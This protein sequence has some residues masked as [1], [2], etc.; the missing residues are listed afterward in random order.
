[1]SLQLAI[2]ALCIVAL[3]GSGVMVAAW[4]GKWPALL[5]FSDGTALLQPTAAIAGLAFA[6]ALLMHTFKL[7]VPALMAAAVPLVLGG[8]TLAAGA[9]GSSLFLDN[10]LGT[11]F[12]SDEFT[13]PGRM[14]AYTAIAFVCL[15]L[16]V[17][18]LALKP[19][20]GGVTLAAGF[21]SV[22][23]G[24][25]G[26]SSLSYLMGNLADFGWGAYNGV[27]PQA[28]VLV[29]V[30]ATALMAQC[31]LVA[32]RSEAGAPRGF[33]LPVGLAVL[34]S[35][36]MAFTSFERHEQLRAGEFARLRA[37]EGTEAVNR[38]I[39]VTED[40]VLRIALLMAEQ[41][42][43]VQHEWESTVQMTENDLPGLIVCDIDSRGRRSYSPFGES[44]SELSSAAW[45]AAFPGAL[46]LRQ[47]VLGS[48]FVSDVPY[49]FV[50]ASAY[51]SRGH[52]VRIVAVFEPEAF[53]QSAL[54]TGV[55]Q[56][57]ICELQ[58]GG[59]SVF[60]SNEL[61]STAAPIVN[62]LRA[63]GDWH[64][65][66]TPSSAYMDS[67][68]SAASVTALTAGILMIILLTAA[69]HLALV[70]RAQAEHL[71][72]AQARTLESRERIEMLVASLPD[73]VLTVRNDGE[74]EDV[75]AA[76]VPLFALNRD[77]LVGRNIEELLGLD[78]GG[79]ALRNTKR[80]EGMSALRGKVID[81][82]VFRSDGQPFLASIRVASFNTADGRKYLWTVSDISWRHKAERENQRLLSALRATN[83]ELMHSAEE[84]RENAERFAA[85]LASAPEATILVNESGT[86]LEFNRQAEE[87]LGYTREEAVGRP[88]EI[89]LPLPMRE[90]HVGL[91]AEYLKA[92]DSRRMARG[93]DLAA[94]A[95]S[96]T[97]IPV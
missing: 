71:R 65:R 11:P 13:H 33:A 14:A 29:F 96:G 92:P 19:G 44:Q 21:G 74:I 55:Q 46:E 32:P 8:L 42:E 2:R 67:R 70:S 72:A 1:M 31:W 60:K 84:A 87:L 6:A 59:T 26:M 95:K 25:G 20:N 50:A 69:T 62:R 35:A 37:V 83:E 9:L 81:A 64:L 17:M 76:A 28:A 86:M 24:V 41:N 7:R 82:E 16:G 43:V 18:L 12:I 47:P 73:A 54:P 97:A 89:L 51:G 5:K 40:T 4:L 90:H 15:S 36:V 38:R 58:A 56:Q 78:D 94:L 34:V 23:V 79:N 49:L 85:L 10:L 27:S 93:R 52:D 80:L 91:R 48:M 88:V 39:D 75:N 30:L 45:R 66:M 77:E 22:A 61:V 53:M 3:I 68:R 57:F 63:N